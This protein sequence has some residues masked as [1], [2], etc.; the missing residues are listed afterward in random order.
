MSNHFVTNPHYL[1]CH[2]ENPLVKLNTFIGAPPDQTNP[3]CLSEVRSRL[4]SP[5]W[6][7]EAGG[8]AVACYWRAWELAF[9]NLRRVLPK[10]GIAPF[11]DTAFND[12][13]F[14]WDSAFIMMFCKYGRAAFNFQATLDNLYAKQHPDGFISREVQEWDGADRFHRHD[15]A[16][17]GPNVLAWCEWQYFEAF[18]DEG[19]LARVFPVLLAYHQWMAKHRTWPDG[20][21]YSCGLACGMDNQPRVPPGDSAWSDNGFSAWVDATAQAV[22]S[23]KT[24]LRMA[25]VLGEGDRP[26][27][28]ALL[29]EASSL[30]QYMHDH[31]W[32]G[33]TGT[34]ADRRLRPGDGSQLSSVRTVGAYWTL[35]ADVVSP[36]RV[37]LFV[38]ALDDPALFNR[39]VRVP[40]LAANHPEYRRDGGYWLGGVWPPTTY[41]VLKGLTHVGGHDDM[42]ADIAANYHECCVRLWKSSGTLWE[43]MAPEVGA[44]GGP[45]PGEP[46]KKDF[47]GWS[48]LG[49]ITIMFECVWRGEGE[50]VC[51]SSPPHSTNL[52]P[53][54]PSHPQVRFWAAPRRS[55][56]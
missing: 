4:P 35:L 27:V 40:T 22:L 25:E 53:V 14:M 49:P 23:A 30:S 19:R 47:V 33:R 50:G 16:S 56:G 26:E 28:E 29:L 13:L 44:G 38:G 55:Q 12:C 31:M 18:G 10:F 6:D 11:I 36:E 43:N 3:P 8:D 7:G 37:G 9:F 52:T 48:G 1:D 41:M 24:L 17:T 54:P 45:R 46:S 5:F 51:V 39:P 20:S 32:D 42:A 34:F 21:Y 2:H 15:P